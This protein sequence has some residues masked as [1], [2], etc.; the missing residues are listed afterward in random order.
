MLFAGAG[1][2]LRG[3]VARADH[4]YVAVVT[5]TQ[6]DPDGA[7]GMVGLPLVVEERPASPR[8]SSRGA[9]GV[10]MPAFHVRV[11]DGGSQQ[12]VSPDGH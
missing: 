3:S 10:L 6:L 12:S 8:S 1:L 2:L 5:N 4:D 11:A 7:P 9:I